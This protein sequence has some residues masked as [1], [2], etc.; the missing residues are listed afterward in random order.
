M[1]KGEAF[2]LTWNDISF[3]DNKIHINK[4]ISRGKN[5]QLYLKST[6]TGIA[7]TI[8]MDSRTIAILK[9]WQKKQK[10]TILN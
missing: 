4:A 2:A 3:T 5:N 6:R 1:R 8:A 10:K 7:R 9:E